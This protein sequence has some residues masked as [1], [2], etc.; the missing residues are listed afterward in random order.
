[1]EVNPLII[2]VAV[3]FLAEWG[4]IAG[5]ILAVPLT[6]AGHIVVSVLLRERRQRLDIPGTPP[7]PELLDERA[8]DAGSESAARH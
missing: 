4:G 6:A 2:I 1:V 5:A 7:T 8:P 3:L